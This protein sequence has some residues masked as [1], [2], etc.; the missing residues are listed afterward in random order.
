M[1]TEEAMAQGRVAGLDWMNSDEQ[2]DNPHSEA[3]L[4][5][6]WEIGFWETVLD[7]TAATIQRS[8]VDM[9][10]LRRGDGN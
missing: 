6:A 2:I 8:F 9:P 4:F 5:D 3:G 10:F 1:T 7:K